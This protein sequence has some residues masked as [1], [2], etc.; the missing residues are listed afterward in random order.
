MDRAQ[1]RAASAASRRPDAARLSFAGLFGHLP[2]L[3]GR[4][5]RLVESL[6][7]ATR[8]GFP[9]APESVAGIG[10][11]E[12]RRAR[13]GN[14]ALWIGAAALVAI[15]LSDVPIEVMLVNCHAGRP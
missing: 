11:A 13:W 7:D 8:R 14:V 2:R 12:A 4:A 5:E 9:L 1:S 10:R 6:E 15:A 3:V